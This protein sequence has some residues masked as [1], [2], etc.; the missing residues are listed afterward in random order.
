M[1]V[2]N[3][4]RFQF[5]SRSNY[6]FFLNNSTQKLRVNMKNHTKS[7]FP[8]SNKHRSKKNPFEIPM[9]FSEIIFWKRVFHKC[10]YVYMCIYV[11]IYVYI[12]VYVY[13]CIYMYICVYIYIYIHMWKILY[14]NPIFELS[15]GFAMSFS[16]MVLHAICVYI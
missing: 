5:Q 8:K 7:S 16:G 6:M 11:C 15:I 10:I 4:C 9:P 2:I 12:C 13:I 14:R 1:T 3:R